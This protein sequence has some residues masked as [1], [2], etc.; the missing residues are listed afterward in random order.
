MS[1]PAKYRLQCQ[2]RCGWPR[3]G[4]LYLECVNNV[5]VP[6]N[7]GMTMHEAQSSRPG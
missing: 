6:L 3:S 1:D 2:I 5:R 7:Q 4:V